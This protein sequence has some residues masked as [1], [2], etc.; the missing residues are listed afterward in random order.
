MSR[1]P[2]FLDGRIMV[3]VVVVN[4]DDGIAT[5]QQAQGQVGANKPGRVSDEDF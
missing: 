5:I 4:A 1:Q 2:R 3:V